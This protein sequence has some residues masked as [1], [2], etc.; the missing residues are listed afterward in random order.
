M[1]RHPAEGRRPD[2]RIHRR[3]F[4]QQGR[5]RRVD[6]DSRAAVEKG[7]RAGDDAHQPR[8]RKL[9]RPRPNQHGR[10]RA[11]RLCEGRQDP[12]ARSVHRPGQRTVWA[13]GRPSIG[14]QR[15]VPD[16]STGGDAVARGQRDDEHA[17]ADATALTRADAGER[18][19]RGVDHEG[20]QAARDRSSGDAAYELSRRQGALRGAGCEGPPAPH[21]QRLCEGS[22]RSRRAAIRLGGARGSC[23][24]TTRIESHRS[25]RGSRPAW[26]GIDRFRRIDDDPAGRQALRAVRRRQSRDALGHRSGARRRRRARDALGE[27][28]RQL[29][30]HQQGLAVDLP[31]GWLARPRMR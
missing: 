2:L 28:R 20:R 24:Q 1:G 11:R 12:R 6:G 25:G 21:H 17:A 13:D 5:R 16:L 26:C 15:R 19:L 23:R 4:W 30:R 7:E 3:R 9:H 14:R 10:P 22:S 8:G 29:G 31:L 18:P 27:S